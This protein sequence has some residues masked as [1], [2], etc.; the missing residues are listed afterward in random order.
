MSFTAHWALMRMTAADVDRFAPRIRP[1]LAEHTAE[2]RIREL[3][4]RWEAGLTDEQAFFELAAAC[5]LDDHIEVVF[6]AWEAGHHTGPYLHASCRKS[7]PMAGLAHGLGPERFAALPGWFGDLLLDPDE[8][9]ATLPAVEA[10]LT[11]DGETRAAVIARASE[12]LVEGFNEG[13][14][15]LLDGILWMW[16]AAA[17]AGHGLIGAQ[18]VPT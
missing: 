8:V 4:R 14:D 6:E 16:R 13:A 17:E 9:R 10:A 11:L 3:R 2:P 15:A 18:V 7:Y 1:L 12:V 5:P